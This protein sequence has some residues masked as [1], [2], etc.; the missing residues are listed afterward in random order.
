M[1]AKNQEKKNRRKCHIRKRKV[2]ILAT[3][4]C[5]YFIPI[6]LEP[7]QN[8][9]PC[10]EKER[11]R[12]SYSQRI[13]KLEFNELSERPQ[14][15]LLKSSLVLPSPYGEKIANSCQNLKRQTLQ[16]STVLYTLNQKSWEE[17]NKNSQNGNNLPTY[18]THVCST[19]YT[20]IQ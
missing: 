10:S 3:G 12:E 6:A 13:Q 16:D 14:N 19:K 9:L 1:Y 18:V 11:M 8:V 5:Y 2:K 7:Y 20:F 4:K 17:C 15:C